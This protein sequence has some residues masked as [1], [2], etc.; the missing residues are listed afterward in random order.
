MCRAEENPQPGF[1]PLLVDI[2][3]QASRDSHPS[4]SK[5]VRRSNQHAPYGD[6]QDGIGNEIRED[7]ERQ[8][9]QQWHRRFLL[10][11]IQE[12]AKTYRAKQQTPKNRRCIHCSLTSHTTDE[13]TGRNITPREV[14]AIGQCS[15]NIA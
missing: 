1:Q 3:L 13:S 9:T 15:S 10:P 4:D 6:K 2:P 12:K 7:H 5:E 8:P 14:R 11:S